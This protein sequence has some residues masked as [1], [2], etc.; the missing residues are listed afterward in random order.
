MIRVLVLA[1]SAAFVLA[2]AAAYADCAGHAPK[3]AQAASTDLAAKT[4]SAPVT[5][6]DGNGSAAQTAPAK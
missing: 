5:T 6:T 1:V 2:P 3:T 4:K